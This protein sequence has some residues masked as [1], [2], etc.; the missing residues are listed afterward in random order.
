MNRSMLEQVAASVSDE[1]FKSAVLRCCSADLTA[2]LASFNTGLHPDDQMF[3]HSL[4]QHQNVDAA[5]SQYFNV[6]LQQ[7]SCVAQITQ[8]LFGEDRARIEFLD[9]A[10]GFGR[11]LRFLVLAHD[12]Q[13]IHASEIQPEAIE[14]VG[15]TFGIDALPSNADPD[16]FNTEQR[17]DFIW[18]ASLFTHLPHE[19]FQRWLAKLFALLTPQ[20][21][22]C[23]SVRDASQLQSGRELPYD[24]FLYELQS[25]NSDLSTEIYGTTYATE[26]FVRAAVES[27]AR[28][29]HPIQRLRRALANEQDL[30]LVGRDP[31]RNFDCLKTFRRGEW[32]WV[33]RRTL[34]QDGQ[35][36]L[37]GWAAS[38]DEGPAQ[39]VRVSVDGQV[40]LLQPVIHRPDVAAAFDDERLLVSGWSLMHQFEKAPVAARVEVIAFDRSRPTA[41]LFT[42]TIEAS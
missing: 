35:L 13:K 1:R 23:F 14:Y 32:G 15:K 19:L 25:E 22:L 21:V 3:L 20:G 4:R 41:L 40:Y 6:A 16:L 33:D 18:V 31:R 38:L 12:H 26:N 8:A 10:C 24:G 2:Q 9:F 37:E 28:T 34:S 42:G 7:Y 29:G 27:F 30:Y 5:L 11:L 39:T 17:F 36:Y